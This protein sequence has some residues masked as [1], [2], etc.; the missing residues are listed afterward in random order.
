MNLTQLPIFKNLT[1]QEIEAIRDAGLTR[2]KQFK[3]GDLIFSMGSETSSLGII[4]KGSV[5]IEN[6]DLWGNKSILSD[7]S[8]GQIFGE[9]Y[10][11]TGEMLLVDAVAAEDSEILF[12]NVKKMTGPQFRQSS[13][14]PVMIMNLLM[15]SSRKNL[16]LSNRIFHTSSKRVRSRLQSYLSY[17]SLKA[18]S[19]EFDIPF[20]RQQLA[21]YLN[22]DRTALSKELGRMREE[23]IL[24]FKKNHFILHQSLE[25]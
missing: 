12:L 1:E 15:L 10:A 7:V 2:Q 6:I 17:C 23:G 9:T 25:G 14:F 24:D 22:L 21:D 11:L 20:D 5:N 19:K 16:V 8:A 18:R 13:W 3:K 4:L